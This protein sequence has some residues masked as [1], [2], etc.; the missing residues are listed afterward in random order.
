M[1]NT[2]YDI[3]KKIAIAA[4]VVA[5][6]TALGNGINALLN[7]GSWLT[8]IFSTFKLL[9]MP[10]DY[11]IDITSFVAVVGLFLSF[12]ILIWSLRAGIAVY[13]IINK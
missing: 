8:D 1:T 2:V 12:T 11:I 6:L 3:L 13:K 5:A 7:L 9:L 4:F 10:L